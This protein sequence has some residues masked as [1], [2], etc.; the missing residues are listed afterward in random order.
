MHIKL[1]FEHHNNEERFKSSSLWTDLLDDS[2]SW[3]IALE[4]KEQCVNYYLSYFQT[5]QSDKRR[6]GTSLT[7]DVLVYV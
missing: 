7:G 5:I 4:P 3:R 1:H 6:I 2:L